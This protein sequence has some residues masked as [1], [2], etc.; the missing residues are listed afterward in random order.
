VAFDLRLGK[1]A[2]EPVNEFPPFKEKQG[3]DALGGV[4]RCGHMVLIYIQFC[5]LNPTC[6]LRSELIEDWGHHTAG[7]APRGPAIHQY[8][9]RAG[10]NYVAECTIRYEHRTIKEVPRGERPAALGAYRLILQPV[11]GHT[12]LRTAIGTS[13]YNAIL[14]H[15]L[16][17]LPETH[18]NVMVNHTSL[19]SKPIAL[20]LT[21]PG[22]V[23]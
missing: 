18:D 2:N 7:T 20:T 14:I 11:P 19:V 17:P 6:I 13:K 8:R 9:V 22:Q 10:E 1:G 21:L 15:A 4:P 23:T 12:V 16:P 3:W 5:D